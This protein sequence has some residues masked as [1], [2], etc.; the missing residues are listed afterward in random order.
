MSSDTAA[1]S[2]ESKPTTDDSTVLAGSGTGQWHDE[3]SDPN[4]KG[5]SKGADT[6]GEAL[7][8]H[9]GGESGTASSREEGDHDSAAAEL[10]SESTHYHPRGP[11]NKPAH[12]GP[13]PIKVIKR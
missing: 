2:K 6:K 5:T 8:D 9:P 10:D 3:K 7:S 1:T 4:T 12:G 13:K 11:P